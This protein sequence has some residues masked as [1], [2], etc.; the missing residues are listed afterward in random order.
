M[1]G[2]HFVNH[3]QGPCR[4]GLEMGTMIGK[5]KLLRLVRVYHGVYWSC[6]SMMSMC[7]EV[8][9]GETN[10]TTKRVM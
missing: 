8:G 3:H 7:L 2:I 10:L 4:F 1:G 6:L 5:Q 9:L